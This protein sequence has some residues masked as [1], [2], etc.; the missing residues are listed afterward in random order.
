MGICS[1]EPARLRHARA[2]GGEEG[3]GRGGGRD[4]ASA[5]TEASLPPPIPA[6]PCAGGAALAPR[7]P[8]PLPTPAPGERCA[9]EPGS[10]RS[11]G[12]ASNCA[13][14]PEATEISVLLPRFARGWKGHQRGQVSGAEHQEEAS[15]RLIWVAWEGSVSVHST[16]L[17]ARRPNWHSE[18][19]VS[20]QIVLKSYLEAWRSMGSMLKTIICFSYCFS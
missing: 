12:W 9:G 6:P 18:A 19:Q 8:G 14:R 2:R 4:P 7:A 11:G 13:W 15:A 20:H 10:P 17:E 16:D 5:E 3:L 1:A